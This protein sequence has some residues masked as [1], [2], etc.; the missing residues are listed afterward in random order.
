MAAS[1][2]VRERSEPERAKVVTFADVL[3][4]DRW[5]QYFEESIAS[6]KLA[7]AYLLM[8]APGVGK[9]HF[10]RALAARIACAAPTPDGACG[11]CPACHQIAAGTH[12]DI[13]LVDAVAEGERGVSVETARDRVLAAFRL[14]PSL[15]PLRI[16]VI[17]DADRMELGAQNALLK[18]L[19]EPPARSL[20]ILIA[21]DAASLLDTVLSRCFLL[22]FA[23]VP[24]EALTALLVRRGL[25]AHDAARLAVLAEGVPGRAMEWSEDRVGAVDGMAR[26]LLTGEMSPA[27]VSQQVAAL[28]DEQS[29]S[30]AFERRRQAS[31]ALLAAMAKELRERAA[32]SDSMADARR[33]ERV[34]LAASEL[35]A[36]ATPELVVDRL[37]WAVAPTISASS[38]K[39]ARLPH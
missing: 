32:A 28:A 13:T 7:H 19:E 35:A 3:G 22:R 10:A 12:P 23:P 29:E 30:S 17:N 14:K 1:R 39:G 6:G 24:T 9:W 18:T 36:S 5:K 15:S 11:R 4:H 27:L 21:R 38:I 26:A 16:V 20:L 33:L 2:A 31:W 8:G 34:V 25:P 37:A